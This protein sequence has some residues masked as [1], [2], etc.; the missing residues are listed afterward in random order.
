MWRNLRY[1]FTSPAQTDSAEWCGEQTVIAL[2]VFSIRIYMCTY[3]VVFELICILIIIVLAFSGSNNE[4]TG[5][6]IDQ[7]SNCVYTNT[8]GW[9]RVTDCHVTECVGC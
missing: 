2:G 3:I 6:K 7:I 5:M 4:L 8:K 9:V 1:T